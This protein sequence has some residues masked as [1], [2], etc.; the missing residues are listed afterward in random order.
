M[1]SQETIPTDFPKLELTY[2]N[3]VW[4]SETYEWENVIFTSASPQM[5]Y[6]F[7]YNNRKMLVAFF[8]GE[9]NGTANVIGTYLDFADTWQPVHQNK[10]EYGQIY[11]ELKFL[12]TD[13]TK[14]V[15]FEYRNGG[16]SADNGSHTFA[17][18]DI[19]NNE[20]Y[21]LTYSGQND[22]EK[23]YMRVKNGTFDL[24]NLMEYPEILSVL[25]SQAKDS[26]Y[27]VRN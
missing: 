5:S 16:G 2:E 27:I 18:Y 22:Y 8:F 4:N 26:K 14:Y 25:E 17:L 7:K 21:E 1:F 19:I 9:I 15:Y 11:K 20:L 23:E 10:I 3:E 12:N 24:D 6:E 13:K